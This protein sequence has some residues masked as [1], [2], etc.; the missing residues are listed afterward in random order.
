MTFGPGAAVATYTTTFGWYQNLY[1]SKELLVWMRIAL[2]TPFPLVKIFQLR[3]D[4]YFD[5][6]FSTRMAYLFRVVVLQLVVAFLMVVWMVLPY[7]ISEL[8]PIIALGVVLGASAAPF[9]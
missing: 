1:K 4:T 8:V 6:V 7:N 9:I 2:F 5:E 3:Y